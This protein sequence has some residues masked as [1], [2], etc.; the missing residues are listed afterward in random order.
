MALVGRPDGT[1]TT[2]ATK[3]SNSTTGWGRRW[4]STSSATTDAVSVRHRGQRPAG[5][6][7]SAAAYYAPTWPRR[8][9]RTSR[10]AHEWI[11]PRTAGGRRPAGNAS[12]AGADG[13]GGRGAHGEDGASWTGLRR[14]PVALHRVGSPRRAQIVAAD[15]EAVLG[16]P[17]ASQW[18]PGD[19]VV[20][21]HGDDHLGGRD[22]GVD[23]LPPTSCPR[24][25]RPPWGLPPPSGNGAKPMASGGGGEP[26]SY[27]RAL[28]RA[29]PPISAGLSL[30]ITES[31]D[32]AEGL[33]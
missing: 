17:H 31:A 21:L 10:R 1:L 28:P 23:P 11:R 8:P 20:I 12:D 26:E 13:R 16:L 3:P 33:R 32:G 22:T 15:Q 18:S 6:P 2:L 14:G 30:H 9:I 19:T 25:D 27:H 24:A 7:T 29:R 5:G 4:A